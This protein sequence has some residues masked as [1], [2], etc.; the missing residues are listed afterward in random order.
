MTTEYVQRADVLITHTVVSDTLH[1]KPL[2]SVHSKE[3][4]RCLD[5]MNKLIGEKVIMGGGG[6]GEII[7]RNGTSAMNMY[8]DL[9][10]LYNTPSGKCWLNGGGRN[11][12]RYV[13]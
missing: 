9:T 8:S 4:A 12:H 11:R 7:L 13:R 10:H 2:N 6:G 3:V 5:E 1:A